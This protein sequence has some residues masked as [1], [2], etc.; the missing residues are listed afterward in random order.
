[1]ACASVGMVFSI[2]VIEQKLAQ[3]LQPFAWPAE[4]GCSSWWGEPAWSC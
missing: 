2:G 1:M 3:T 4:P